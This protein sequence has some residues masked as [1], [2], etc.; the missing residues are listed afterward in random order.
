MTLN[1]KYKFAQTS[2]IEELWTNK[3]GINDGNDRR[4]EEVGEVRG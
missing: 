2:M 4:L 3:T 1:K